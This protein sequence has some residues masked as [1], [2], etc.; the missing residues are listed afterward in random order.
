MSKR[1]REEGDIVPLG[2]SM[3]PVFQKKAAVASSRS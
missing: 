1:K 2:F 3:P